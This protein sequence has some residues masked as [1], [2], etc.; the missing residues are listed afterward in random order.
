MSRRPSPEL[1][2]ELLERASSEGARALLEKL[3]APDARTRMRGLDAMTDLWLRDGDAD[4][5]ALAAV[6]TLATHRGYPESSALLVRLVRTLAALD[7]PPR[8]GPPSDVAAVRRWERFREAAPRL[9]RHARSSS[10]PQAAR[11]ASV[12]AGRFPDLDAE[13]EPLLIAL[14]SGAPDADERAR[15]VYALTR[16]QAARGA[17][18][19]GA[20]AE[21]L[22]H[23]VEPVVQLGAALALA[24]HD[25][26]EPLRGRL[27]A[28]LRH[29]RDARSPI[30][31]PRTWGR[32]LPLEALDRALAR[33][34]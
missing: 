11:A 22:A 7:D 24:E 25:P 27:V 17:A 10:D 26:P 2:A 20:I 23:D 29:A 21:A 5:E 31:D 16:I 1:R 4:D 13:T 3:L 9:V 32:T 34:A 8:G 33:L 15:L 19:H 18:F 30:Q 6:L 28:L 14:L 12:L